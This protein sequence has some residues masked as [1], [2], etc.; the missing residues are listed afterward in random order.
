[1]TNTPKLKKKQRLE[2]VRIAEYLVSGGAYFW[3]AYILIVFLTP[4]IGLWWANLIGNGVGVT[5]NFILERYWVFT[6]SKSR[7]LTYVTGKYVIYTA[8][9]FL[10]SYVILRSLQEVGIVV[11]IGQFI[12]A[13]FFTVWNYF[14]Y[15]NWVFKGK[16][17]ERR[18]RHH[19]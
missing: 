10:L 5:L 12:S 9:N 2:L 18:V 1:M 17:N 13:G 8:A 11:A 16:P 4:V 3:S 19:A 7:N 6:S 15:R 14:W